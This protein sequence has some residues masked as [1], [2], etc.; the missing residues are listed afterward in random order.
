M[1][2]SKPRRIMAKVILQ[3]VTED[4]DR[5]ML[6]Q[7]EGEWRYPFDPQV[8]IKLPSY[9]PAMSPRQIVQALVELDNDDLD[10]VMKGLQKHYDENIIGAE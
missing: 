9:W 5:G 1:K 7:P 2:T 4:E 3:I 6:Y 8:P 10:D